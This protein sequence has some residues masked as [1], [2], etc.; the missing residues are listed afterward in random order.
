MEVKAALIRR[1]G[2]PPPVRRH[3]LIQ[4]QRGQRVANRVARSPSAAHS[5]ARSGRSKYISFHT[6][7]DHTLSPVGAPSSTGVQA[8]VAA[9]TS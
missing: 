7:N 6:W 8:P 5:V 9:S 3:D 4:R 2:V 1:L